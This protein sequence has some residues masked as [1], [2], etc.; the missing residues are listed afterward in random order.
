[1]SKA[2]D[3]DIV[4]SR[5][6][7]NSEKWDR[8]D[9]DILPMWVAD[10]DFR[11]PQ[12]LIDVLHERVEH[13]LF[14]YPA[15]GDSYGK[16]AKFWMETR[17]NCQIEAETVLYVNSV[18]PALMDC[19]HAFTKD[20]DKVLIQTPVYPPFFSVIKDADREVVCNSLVENSGEY[21]IDFD[22]FANKIA[23]PAVTMMILCNPHNPVGRAWTESELL[24]MGQLC[25]QHN[26]LMISDDIHQDLVFTPFKYTPIFNISEE[27]KNNSIILINPSKTF[28]IPGLRSA[29]AIAPNLVLRE[30][31]QNCMD[32][33]KSLSP[34]VIGCLA[35]E[36]VYLHCGDYVDALSEY[37]QANR[38]H[39]LQFIKEHLPKIQVIKPE[40][41]YLLWLNLKEYEKSNPELEK[42]LLEVGKIALNDGLTFGE[43]GNGYFRLNFACPKATLEEGLMRLKKA[44]EDTV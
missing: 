38:D 12:K 24:R 33:R 39:A 43:E 9:A 30:K 42:L 37:L 36:T 34:S 35:F 26:V 13:G 22:D 10:S 5:R 28:N 31:L 17:H 14:G 27:I 18:V 29:A 40:A 8:Y 25:V 21:S 41:T 16:A 7:S 3:F 20:G 32:K 6:G 1:M 2:F 4:T 15:E 44:L 11:S 23:D 19:V